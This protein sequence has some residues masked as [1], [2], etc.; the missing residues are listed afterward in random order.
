MS[1]TGH[2][3]ALVTVLIGDF[4][5]QLWETH[6]KPTWEPYAAAHGYDIIVI[7]DYIDRSN[8]AQERRPHWQ[9]C[10]ILEHPDVQDYAHVVWLDGDVAIN[11]H[12]APCVVNAHGSDRIGVL[13]YAN[14]LKYI[15][16]ISVLEQRLHTA[17]QGQP[18]GRRI[19]D[20]YTE[21]GLPGD[22]TDWTNTGVMV[23][24]PPL[25]REV[26][27]AVYDQ[28]EET[29]LSMADNMPLSYHLFKNDL[30][31]PLD[32]RFNCDIMYALLEHYPFILWPAERENGRLRA[33]VANAVWGN[34]YFIHYTGGL[35][36]D[37]RMDIRFVRT[38]R[39]GLI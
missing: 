24:R 37:F 23:L 18:Y 16:G 6:F 32:P 9:K 17:L 38:A 4:H 35:G 10:L 28:Y 33:M 11:F 36:R 29:P 26:L 2:A 14:T 31:K 34:N 27:R 13:S 7:D 39:A 22:V 15:D 25:H 30:V 1:A 21:A 12:Q 3:K 20:R 8:K 19:V 5:Q